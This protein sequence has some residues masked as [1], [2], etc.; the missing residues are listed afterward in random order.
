MRLQ[1]ERRTSPVARLLIV[2]D[3]DGVLRALDFADDEDRLH[4]LLGAHY[5]EYTLRDGKS[6]AS[7]NRALDAYFEGDLDGLADLP[8]A[9]AGTPFQRDVWKALRAIPAATTISYGALAARIGRPTAS[10]AVGAANSQNPIAIVVPC[11]RVI[12]ASGALTGYAGG[13]AQKRWLLDHER[14][15]APVTTSG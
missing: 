10:R 12:G 3:D 6:P 5:G 9:T 7:I 4:R 11:H 13:V 8:T 14:R 15:H 1:L 2:T